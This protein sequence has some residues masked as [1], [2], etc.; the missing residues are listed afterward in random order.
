[1]EPKARMFELIG[2]KFKLLSFNVHGLQNKILF[3]EFFNYLKTFDVIYLCETHLEEKNF[4]NLEKYFGGFKLIWTSASRNSSI[5]RGI[6]GELIA[7]KTSLINGNVKVNVEKSSE[8]V[9]INIKTANEHITIIPLY[10]RA[11]TWWNQFN[12]IKTFFIEHAPSNVIIMG[13][14]NIRIGEAQQTLLN[15]NYNH[16]VNAVRRSKDKIKNS[17]GQAFLDFCDD[18]SLLLLNG[19]THDDSNGEFTFSTRVGN[20][21][22]DICVIDQ[23]IL[24]LLRDFEVGCGIWSDHMPITTTLNLDKGEREDRA[25][26]PGK[27][28]WKD[29]SKALYQSRLNSKLSTNTDVYNNCRSL[30]KLV[31]DSNPNVITRTKNL[32]TPREPWF[33]ITCF[34]QKKKVS[35]RLKTWRNSDSPGDKALYYT[36]LNKYK[37]TRKQK[38]KSYYENLEKR[39]NASSKTSTW[40]KLVKELKTQPTKVSSVLT[41]DCFKDHFE[42]L[43]N[44]PQISSDIS[45]AEPWIAD[46]LLDSTITFDEI[47]QVLTSL[48]NNKAAGE[49]GVPYEFYKHASTEFILQLRDCFSKMF[50]EGSTEEQF[51]KTIT[52]P[53]HKKGDA[54]VTGNYRAISL[55]D[56]ISKIFM[57]VLN[58]RLNKWLEQ[59]D[60]LSESQA[61]FRRGYSTSDNIYN[62]SCI[63]ELKK[64]QKKKVYAFFVDFRAAFD[65]VTRKSL[66]YKLL[67]L[68]VST[69]FV[70]MVQALYNNTSTAVMYDGKI[71]ESFGTGMGVK[72]GCLLSP[73]LFAIYLDDIGDEIG[74]GLEVCGINVNVLMY[75]D[76][77]VLLADDREVLQRMIDKLECYCDNWNMVVNTEKSKILVFKAGGRQAGADQWSFKGNQIE[78]VKKYCYLGVIFTQQLSFKEH[79]LDREKKAKN[80]L[81]MVWNGFMNSENITIY[82]KCNMFDSVSR[83]MLIHGAPAYGYKYFEDVDKLKIYFLKRIMKLPAFTPTYIL[84]LE[85]GLDST[86]LHTLEL[87]MKYVLKTIF[88]YSSNR[89]PHILSLAI[90]DKNTYWVPYWT[91]LSP[92][93]DWSIMDIDVWKA[94]IQK[95]IISLREQIFENCLERCRGTSR[96]YKLLDPTKGVTYF[97]NENFSR[98]NI[99]WI[100]KARASMINLNSVR[101]REGSRRICSLCSSR[102]EETIEHFLGI[103]TMFKRIRIRYF[104]KSPLT[105]EEIIEILNS[106]WMKLALYVKA[107]ISYRQDLLARFNF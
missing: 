38:F 15:D 57:G 82:C 97:H 30:V 71:S 54:D 65:Y 90:Q 73:T 32:F 98:Q 24:H 70:R 76:D 2:I 50:E 81:N 4:K 78:V 49:D 75:A 40:W 42:G 26:W 95:T 91:S 9:T 93:L 52:C 48:K 43:L 41:A 47:V 45:Y 14:L 5:G 68:G 84:Q 64:L 56:C 103:C 101:W 85:S 86:H 102:S 12:N 25:V 16:I 8:V 28:K 74:G 61:G 53:L 96:F 7:F 100:F 106:E 72:Q 80:N 10:L 13:D 66:F 107:A 77:I 105:N 60:K 46:P 18:Y 99:M 51:L 67:R 35:R 23:N 29:S 62:L 58:I 22:N 6:G 44:P 104:G 88:M 1:M 39:I 27:L 59:N 31:K 36:A 79:I 20:S 11:E 55:M 87:H 83:A 34:N 33:D 19:R 21:V 37:L 17:R 63:V 94:N 69:K 92:D 3:P 89:L